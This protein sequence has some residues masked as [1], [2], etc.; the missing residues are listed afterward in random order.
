MQECF[1]L[2]IIGENNSH[3][4]DSVKVLNSKIIIIS[5]FLFQFFLNQY[6]NV[7]IKIYLLIFFLILLY[8]QF[9][10]IHYWICFYVP[11]WSFDLFSYFCMFFFHICD[12]T[13]LKRQNG[14]VLTNPTHAF[15]SWLNIYR[16]F[17]IVVTYKIADSNSY[18]LRFYFWKSL[19]EYG[20]ETQGLAF[21]GFVKTHPSRCFCFVRSH[22]KIIRF[23]TSIGFDFFVPF[24]TI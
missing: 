9:N 4:M 2:F 13:E 20:T 6:L 21:G 7:L 15:A 16:G 14:C 12:H 11:N 18:Q 3:W 10:F 19:N 8:V 1:L 17:F 24:K 23:L 5:Y 22:I